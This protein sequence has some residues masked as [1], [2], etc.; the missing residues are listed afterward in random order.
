MLRAVSGNTPNP[1]PTGM[2]AAG[3]KAASGAYGQYQNPVTSQVVAA[4]AVPSFTLTSSFNTPG[5][6]FDT[7]GLPGGI[8]GPDGWYELCI[9]WSC[10]NSA[11]SKGIGLVVNHTSLAFTDMQTTNTSSTT[12][13]RI[14]NSN[15][16]SVNLVDGGPVPGPHAAGYQWLNVDLSGFNS[17]AIWSSGTLV[18]G[19]HIRVERWTLTAH[20]PPVYST[21]RLQQGN[22]IFYGGNSHWDDGHTPAQVIAGMKTMGMKVL[23]ITDEGGTSMTPITAI[24]QAFQADNTGLQVM[25][26]IDMSISPDGTNLYASE[27]AAYNAAFA[28]A[29]ADCLLLKPYGVTMYECGNEMDTKFGINIGDP[30]GGGPWMFD[31]TKTNIF[32]GIQRGAID[33]VHSVPGCTALSN[34]YTVCSIGLADMMWNGT[35]PDGSL[36][37]SGPIRWDVTSWHNYEDYGAMT[38]VE[39]FNAGPWVNLFQEL[40]RRYGGLPIFVTEWNAKASDTDAQRAVWAN[41]F[42]YEGYANRYKY[43]IAGLV[44][45][46]LWGSPWNVLNTDGTVQSTFGTTVQSFISSNPD[47]GS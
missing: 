4:S 45:Y 6:I 28:A 10:N 40:N 34:A 39:M 23:R 20:N 26:C 12:R 24:A 21:K 7:I 35:N 13:V 30:Q 22:K 3:I 36:A 38:G 29:R 41:R 43:N 42:M 31:P 47:S 9:D 44:V 33:G 32:R 46:E 1:F 25:L 8:V 16:T 14:S 18:S 2:N 19:D 15:S 11:T 37:A 27:Q 17:V 5:C